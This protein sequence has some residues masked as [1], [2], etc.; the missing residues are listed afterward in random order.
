MTLSN[1][2][3]TENSTIGT[4]VGDLSAVDP[5]VGDT[6]TFELVAGTG[7]DDNA[8]FQI[9]GVELQT[10]AVLDYEESGT[11]SV[12]VEVDDGQ[13]GTYQEAF[14]ITVQNENEA[15]TDI[16]LSNNTVAEDAVIGTVVGD[17]SAV[18]PDVGDTHTFELV[19]GTGDDDNALFQIDGVEL[20]TAAV[21]DYEE[22]GTRSVLVEVDDGQ[23]GTYQEAFV[24]TVQDENEAPTDIDLSNNTVAENAVIGT[25]VGDLS[26]VDP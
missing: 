11:R 13:G 15:P 21:L 23:G 26:A 6:H 25:V 19:A 14:V 18:D 3:I 2:T 16:D 9:D 7:D 8:L 4:V 12:L 24:I 5:D 22:S 17:L 1:D 20:Q 10:A